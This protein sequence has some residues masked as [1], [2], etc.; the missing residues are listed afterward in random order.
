MLS[1]A[2]PVYETTHGKIAAQDAIL[3]A[4]PGSRWRAGGT[5]GP[6][7]NFSDVLDEQAVSRF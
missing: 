3:A 7:L 4:D 5:A 2:V 1:C 6:D